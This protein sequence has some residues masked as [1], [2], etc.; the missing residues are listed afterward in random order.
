MKTDFVFAILAILALLSTCATFLIPKSSQD[1]LDDKV[2]DL[3]TRIDGVS[4]WNFSKIERDVALSLLGTIFLAKPNTIRFWFNVAAFAALATGISLLPYIFIPFR[5]PLNVSL[6]GYPRFFLMGF[7]I[8]SMIFG[9]ISM[10]TTVALLSVGAKVPFGIIYIVILVLDG[11]VA[12]ALVSALSINLE[13]TRS[14]LLALYDGQTTTDRWLGLYQPF[15]ALYYVMTHPT[16]MLEAFK[17]EFYISSKYTTY[18]LSVVAMACSL[19]PL[20]VHTLAA[21]MIVLSSIFHDVTKRVVAYMFRRMH[22]QKTFKLL[23]WAFGVP[24][25]SMKILETAK[26]GF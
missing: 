18:I 26:L 14:Y 23:A 1:A 19:I 9:V 2:K 12:S 7:F 3:S 11:L 21:M 8:P 16:A 20:F 25:V 24:A 10:T 6:V 4:F 17:T 22:E 5:D 15:V 13:L